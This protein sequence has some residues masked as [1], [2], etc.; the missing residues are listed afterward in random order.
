MT[1]RQ[2]AYVDQ[3]LTREELAVALKVSPSTVDRWRREGMPSELWGPRSGT[4]RFPLAACLAWARRRG[5]R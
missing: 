3:W 2:L 1:V 5:S 4:R